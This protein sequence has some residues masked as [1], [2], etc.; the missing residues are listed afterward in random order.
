MAEVLARFANPISARTG[1]RYFAQVCTAP[2]DEGMW[3][4]WIEFLPVEGGL[5]LRS[6][7]ETSQPNKTDAEYWAAGLSAICLE[8]ALERALTPAERH[9][10][11][12][13]HSVGHAVLDPYSLYE[14]GERRLRQELGALSPRHLVNIVGAYRLS[15]DSLATLHSMSA[16]SLIDL[17]IRRVKSGAPR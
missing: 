10:A 16:N 17:I 5:P 14:K 4:G 1:E 9:V 15:D 11:T 8:G 6:P 7:R 12:A 3:V 2:N 13:T